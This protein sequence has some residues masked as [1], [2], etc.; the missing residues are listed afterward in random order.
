MIMLLSGMIFF[1]SV[2]IEADQKSMVDTVSDGVVWVADSRAAHVA[3]HVLKWA[4]TI[5]GLAFMVVI[6]KKIAIMHVMG[7]DYDEHVYLLGSLS[8][9]E[10]SST[11]AHARIN[12]LEDLPTNRREIKNLFK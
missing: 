9:V 5:G 10:K 2:S 4:A 1:T 12:V 7:F 3:Q 6:L 8:A 11:Y